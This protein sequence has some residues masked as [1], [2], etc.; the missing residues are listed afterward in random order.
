MIESTLSSEEEWREICDINNDTSKHN[1][2]NNNNN[3]N[4]SDVSLSTFNK[5]QSFMQ[6]IIE[7]KNDQDFNQKISVFFILLFEIYRVIIGSFLI[8]FTPLKCETDKICTLSQNIN[9]NDFITKLGLIINTITMF[10]F[11][12]LYS[13]EI[14]RENKLI[15]YLE[16]NSYSPSDNESVGESLE[17][18]SMVKKSKILDYDWYYQKAGYLSTIVFLINLI[19]SSFV[20]YNY[21]YDNKSITVFLTNLFFMGLKVIDVFS[22]VNTKKYMFFSA[23]L[24]NRVQFN[25]VD[26]DKIEIINNDTNEIQII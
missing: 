12:I 14:K 8:L 11:L 23:Y 4:N 26:P 7:K 5:K 3:N 19:I 22:I 1:N 2:N 6:L 17:K 18:L 9:R 25:D 16:V 24:K 10:S 13:I 21:Y 20:I 15:T